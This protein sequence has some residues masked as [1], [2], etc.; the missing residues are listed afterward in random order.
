MKIAVPAEVH[1]NERRVAT[2]PDVVGK[3]IDL[4]F[5]IAVESGAGVGA[6]FSDESFAAAG[7][8][9]EF[10]TQTLWR[11]ADIVLKVRSPEHH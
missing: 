2:T 4:G 10:D 6:S 1:P 8:T 7:A 9:I 5:E 11:E 3:L